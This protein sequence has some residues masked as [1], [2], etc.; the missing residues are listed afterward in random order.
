M[1]CFILLA[2]ISK[3]KILR[4]KC[5]QRRGN[6]IG[7]ERETERIN[8]ENGLGIYIN[9]GKLFSPC[10]EFGIHANLYL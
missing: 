9:T 3:M 5:T 10:Y 1:G 6:E 7:R 4:R 2:R 8:G